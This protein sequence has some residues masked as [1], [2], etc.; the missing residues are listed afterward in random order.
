ML[1]H[2][3]SDAPATSNGPKSLCAQSVLSTLSVLSIRPKDETPEEKRD[4]KHLLKDYRKER[5]IERKA[6]TQA[7]KDEKKQQERNA[8]NNRRNMQG[9]TIV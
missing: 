6:N 1:L 8:I 5:R 2:S 7:F 3:S 9:K 4:R